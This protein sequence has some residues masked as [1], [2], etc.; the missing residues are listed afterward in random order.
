MFKKTGNVSFSQVPNFVY[1]RRKVQTIPPMKGNNSG[2]VSE[3]II[4]KNNVPETYP[5]TETLQVGSS[6]DNSIKRDSY[7]AEAKIVGQSSLNAEKPS[8]NSRAVLNSMGPAVLQDQALL[9]GEKDTSY[10]LDVSHLENQV[11]K[12]VVGHENLL[13]FNDSETSH[14]HGPRFSY[15]PNSI[16]CSSDSKPH[17]MEL[18]NGLAG[19]LEFVGCYTHPVPV[20]SVLL[21]TK[22]ND[23]YVCVLCGLLVGKDVSLFIYKLVIEEPRVGHPALV[24][25][26]SVT[27]PDLTDYCGEVSSYM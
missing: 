11:G 4:C 7:C 14:K 10:S 5:S 26:T 22:G 24:G 21:S 9:V 17:N 12:N 15:D 16:P 18:N 13:Q 3:T 20:L 19:I 2:P 23:I 1:T 27:L 6:D 8:M 25:H